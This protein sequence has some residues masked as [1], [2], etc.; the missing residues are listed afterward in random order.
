MTEDISEKEKADSDITGPLSGLRVL[1]LGHFIAAPFCTRVLAD[2][3][4]DVIKV[5]PPGRGDP[6][7]T[8]GAIPDGETSSVWW[9]VHGRNKRCVTADLKNPE[10]I[11]LVKKLIKHADAVVENFK[12]GQ[13]AKWGLGP[14]DIKAANPEAIIVQISGYGQTG[15]YSKRAAFGVIGEAVGGLRHLSGYPKEISD[16]PPVRVGVSIGDSIAGLYGAIGLLAALFEKN[17]GRG[18]AGRR[19]DVALTESILSM[20]EGCLPEYGYM[21]KVRQPQGSTIPTAAP[22]SAYPSKD[23]RWFIIG[24]NSNALFAKLCEVMERPDMAADPRYVDNPSR[25]KHMQILDA[26]IGEW[27]K[28]FTLDELEK[29]I[30]D[31]DIPSSRIYDMADV[32]AD[33]QFIERGMVTPVNDARLGEVLHPGVVP[34]MGAGPDDKTGGGIKW[35]GPGI[36]EHNEDVLEGVLGLDRAEIERLKKENV[37]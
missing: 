37:I 23:G 33:E 30:S 36:G 5:E 10:G 15:P 25:V 3:G 27:T 24:A 4:A 22:S 12:P 7:R 31:A 17:A 20:L 28:Q 32:A 21:D 29:M 18:R 11:E 6:V 14:D 16:L 35:A 34:L 13:L 8:W 19:V 26:E 1:E 2:L 9:S